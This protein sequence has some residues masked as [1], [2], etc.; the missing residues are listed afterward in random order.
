MECVPLE[1]K[2]NAETKKTIILKFKPSPEIMGINKLET[3]PGTEL[4]I[5]SANDST[6]IEKKEA[7]PPTKATKGM[8]DKTKKKAN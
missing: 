8:M 2:I 3:L 1:A 4:S 6:E 5:N 7:T